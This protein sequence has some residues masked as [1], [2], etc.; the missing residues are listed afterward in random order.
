MHH[1]GKDRHCTHS[2]NFCLYESATN[3]NNSSSSQQHQQIIPRRETMDNQSTANGSTPNPK[4]V[5][6]NNPCASA[7]KPPRSS[8]KSTSSPATVETPTVG[9]PSTTTTS[10]PGSAQSTRSFDSETMAKSNGEFNQAV[11]GMAS[12]TE[13]G[14]S[15]SLRIANIYL[16]YIGMPKFQDFKLCHVEN[17]NLENIL[18]KMVSFFHCNPLPAEGFL[19]NFKPKN[20][21]SKKIWNVSSIAQTLSGILCCFREKFPGLDVWPRCK[22]DNPPFWKEAMQAGEKEWKRKYMQIWKNDPDLE[23][24]SMKTRALYRSVDL[25][26]PLSLMTHFH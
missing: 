23:F 5:F 16:S 13:K 6:I 22:T 10:N 14:R 18:L 20:P 9:T 11:L 24:S 7:T 19:E 17:G 21:N 15:N 2:H 26:S 12:S 4:I 1:H 3:S 25:L 8:Q